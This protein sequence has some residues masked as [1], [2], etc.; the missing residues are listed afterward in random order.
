M[1]DTERLTDKLMLDLGA[2]PEQLAFAKGY[3]T[4]KRRARIEVAIVAALVPGSI[5]LALAIVAVRQL[6]SQ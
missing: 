1:S 2:T 3:I 6:F 4:G 5:L